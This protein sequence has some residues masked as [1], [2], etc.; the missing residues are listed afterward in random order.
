MSW[1]PDPLDLTKPPELAQAE[2]PEEEEVD[3]VQVREEIFFSHVRNRP[4]STSYHNSAAV[5]VCR[6]AD[7]VHYPG[8]KCPHYAVEDEEGPRVNPKWTAQV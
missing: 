4:D 5:D 1:L 3:P 2:L 7:G 8:R 6:F